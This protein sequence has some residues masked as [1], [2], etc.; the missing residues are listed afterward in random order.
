[1]FGPFSFTVY[2]VDS[3]KFRIAIRNDD[4]VFLHFTNDDEINEINSMKT[5]DVEIDDK[6]IEKCYQ[7]LLAEQ[8]LKTDKNLLRDEIK[9]INKKELTL[10]NKKESTFEC[11]WDL[12]F[13][14]QV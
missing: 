4:E 1:M 7:I 12:N 5:E 8:K 3:Y 11:D 10:I 6:I 14:K 9:K 2:Y 13:F